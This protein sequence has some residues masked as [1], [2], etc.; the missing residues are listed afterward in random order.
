MFDVLYRNF[1][2]NHWLIFLNYQM[3]QSRQETQKPQ[4]H[5]LNSTKASR[6]SRSHGRR[7]K[8][9]SSTWSSRCRWDTRSRRS[10]PAR[11]SGKK[12][13][14]GWPTTA[15]SKCSTTK[16]TRN[17]FKSCLYSLVIVFLILVSF[18]I[19][20]DLNNIIL[21]YNYN[22]IF[23]LCDQLLSNSTNTARFSQSRYNTCTTRKGQGSGQVK[24][25]RLRDWRHACRS[26]L[27][28]PL[29]VI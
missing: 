4:L 10:S 5:S 8:T 27:H 20:V 3:A 14:S 1:P 9:A 7:G 22:N 23:K 29:L 13:T 16:R 15:T 25:P 11:D 17:P 18:H 24:C 21:I 2:L 26:L 19:N 28:T 12:C 6:C